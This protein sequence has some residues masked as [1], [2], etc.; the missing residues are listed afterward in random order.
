MALATNFYSKGLLRHS[1]KFYLMTIR[2]S[3]LGNSLMW[4]VRTGSNRFVL[5][6]QSLFIC[7]EQ[8]KKTLISSL[9][10][11]CD[12]IYLQPQNISY[13]LDSVLVRES[14]PALPNPD[15]QT[16]YYSNLLHVCFYCF[17][18]K[19]PVFMHGYAWP[20]ACLQA[21]VCACNCVTHPATT[22]KKSKRFHVSPR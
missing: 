13:V 7:S 15:L 16:D 8:A 17:L 18:S 21:C 19:P 6:I 11:S 3:T 20:P 5:Q 9:L 12:T 4:F 2:V 1:G 10:K 14:V 22:M